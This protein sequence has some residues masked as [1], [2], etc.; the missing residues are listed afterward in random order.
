ML[1]RRT[2]PKVITLPNGTTFTSRYQRISRKQLPVNIHVKN[3]PKIGARRKNKAFVERK[4]K[5]SGKGIENLA[6]VG[7]DLG[8]KALNSSIGKKLI[9][10]GID[11]IPNIFKYGVS[12]IKNQNVKRAMTSDIANM[13]VDEAQN[14]I[15]KGITDSLF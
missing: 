8:S 9:N 11:N 6:K 15:K 14:E 13:V 3:T 5:Q 7:L 10:K 4:R 12:K 1:R 2:T